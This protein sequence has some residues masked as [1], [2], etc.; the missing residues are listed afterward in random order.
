MSS[1]DRP[2]IFGLRE[3]FEDFFE[4]S[5][6][7]FVIT[8]GQGKILRINARLTQWLGRAPAQLTG[9]RFSDLLSIGGKIY[10]ETH[11]W[12]LLRMQGYFD[13]VAL[14]L[15]V[16][17]GQKLQVLVNALERKDENNVP[18]FIRVTVFKATDRRQYE[19]NLQL[20]KKQA[21]NNLITERGMSALREQFIAVLGHDL[22]N[23]LGAVKGASELLSRSTLNE[24]D[25]KIVAMIRR[26][27]ERMG[28]LIEN[29]MDFA[30]IRLGTGIVINRQDTVLEPVLNQVVD[31]L[32]ASFRT[33][34]IITSF[35][36][37]E[38]VNCDPS[39]I[40]QL[41]S[42]LLANALTHGSQ[43]T[44]VY[45]NAKHCDGDFE[46]SVSNQG[47]VIPPAILQKIF[48]P[49]TRETARPS[50]HG[51]GLG[52]YIASEISRAHNGELTCMSSEKETK[53]TFRM[54]TDGG[55]EQVSSVNP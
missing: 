51:L 32:R 8:D 5:L 48:E 19:Q 4:N 35:D 42:N 2:T 21:E 30:R 25:S 6:S 15:T 11:L 23:P 36:I 55:S 45:F 37:V 20:A 17:G 38:P 1:S 40:S 7:G 9:Q 46:M 49:F 24:R 14:E 31:E 26:S 18:Q 54:P 12:P 10:Y 43:E 28:E 39:R 16:E 27:C 53:F 33:C 44:P 34:E 47:P 52:L 29:V 3:D 13:E 50:Q 41:L 22:R